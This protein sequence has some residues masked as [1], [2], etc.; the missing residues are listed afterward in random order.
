VAG[1]DTSTLEEGDLELI[2]AGATFP[3]AVWDRCPKH[4][5]LPTAPGEPRRCCLGCH[6]PENAA[7]LVAKFPPHL[8]PELVAQVERQRAGLADEIVEILVK[9]GELSRS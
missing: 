8:R 3:G 7:D 6:I 4:P 9:R 5:G 2:E 1:F